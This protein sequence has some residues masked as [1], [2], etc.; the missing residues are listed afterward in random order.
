LEL[1]VLY[2]ASMEKVDAAAFV[3]A[4]SVALME[5]ATQGSVEHV[6]ALLQQGAD[7]TY[8]DEKGE[9]ESISSLS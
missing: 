5:A 8:Q 6:T 2:S 7:V 9:I 3:E 4:L 1:P